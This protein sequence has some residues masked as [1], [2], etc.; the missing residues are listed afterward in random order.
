MNNSK[1]VIAL[2]LCWLTYSILPAIMISKIGDYSITTEQIDS[3]LKVDKKSSSDQKARDAAYDKLKKEKAL[4]TYALENK[5]SVDDQEIEE[6]FLQKFKKHPKINTNGKFDKQKYDKLKETPELKQIFV[7]LQNELLPL[8]VEKIIKQNY[9]YS[10]DQLVQEF[11]KIKTKLD[12]S[13]VLIEQND[14]RTPTLC[15][16]EGAFKYFKQFRKVYSSKRITPENGNQIWKDYLAY[17]KKK[18]PD[19]L[20]NVSAWECKQ[21]YEQNKDSYVSPDSI[22]L[23]FVFVPVLVDTLSGVKNYQKTKEKA[24]K[25]QTSNNFFKP[26]LTKLPDVQI[27]KTPWTSVEAEFPYLGSLADYQKELSYL[28]K[29]ERFDKMIEM[30]EGCVIVYYL[31]RKK[32]ASISYEDALPS[33]KETLLKEKEYSQTHDFLEKIRKLMLRTTTPDSLYY[34]FGSLKKANDLSLLVNLPEVQNKKALM[35]DVLKHQQGEVGSPLKISDNYYMIYRL[36]KFNK[37]TS[38]DY[39]MQK[40]TFQEELLNLRFKEWLDSY[41]EKNLKY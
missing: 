32:S 41:L 23:A 16:P 35:D 15:S 13:F 2:L 4:L 36:N 10:E 1:F 34:F 28:R 27:S 37:V 39:K 3:L 17:E 30:S 11:L 40:K 24:F 38:A 12:L 29:N 25:I 31:D 20:T 19:Y 9:S 8:K 18:T 22:Q 6:Y 21:Y 26:S 14:A 7:H 5:I 33:I